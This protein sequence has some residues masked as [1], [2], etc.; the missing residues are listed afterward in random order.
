MRVPATVDDTTAFILET[1]KQQGTVA[2]RYF[3]GITDR[4]LCAIAMQSLMDQGIVSVE[5]GHVRLD[6]S[7]RV[8][9]PSKKVMAA[10]APVPVHEPSPKTVEVPAH[11]L[12]RLTVAM[13]SVA[14]SSRAG[15]RSYTSP[16]SY[17]ED[18]LH[19]AAVRKTL[20]TVAARLA[21]DGPT[22]PGTV[23]ATLTRQGEYP[24]PFDLFPEA[25][26]LGLQMG[27]ITENSE[28]LLVYRD[29]SPLVSR[30][31]FESRRAQMRRIRKAHTKTGKD[32]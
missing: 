29:Y 30:E 24:R 17:G 22:S 20:L 31:V 12:D 27:V 26:E 10:P 3:N 32:S 15:S 7:R 11:I 9:E 2:S 13:E 28:G 8:D 18:I 21:D 16:L 1:L 6:I 23:R 4:R 25:A 14:A 5:R 19:T